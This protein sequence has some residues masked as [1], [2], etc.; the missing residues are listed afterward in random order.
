MRLSMETPF[1]KSQTP[2]KGG[3][4]VCALRCPALEM[5]VARGLMLSAWH[6]VVINSKG[7][8]THPTPTP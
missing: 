7:R 2:G 5:S 8:A 6:P 4:L 1:P 3:G